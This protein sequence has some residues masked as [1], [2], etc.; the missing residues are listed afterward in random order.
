MEADSSGRLAACIGLRPRHTGGRA[1]GCETVLE[2]RPCDANGT[3]RSERR[4]RSRRL[5][6]RW[7]DRAPDGTSPSGD[8]PPSRNPRRQRLTE[9]SDAFQET[10]SFFRAY[11]NRCDSTGPIDLELLPHT[12]L[13]S[14]VDG[15]P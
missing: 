13:R 14:Q 8:V 15:A 4:S 11:R 5:G 6:I 12:L 2:I 3:P 7:L 1:E 10:G 9:P